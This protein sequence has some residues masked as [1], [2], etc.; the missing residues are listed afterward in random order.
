MPV[1]VGSNFYNG[2][3]DA[4]RR[5]Q[6]AVDAVVALSGVAPVNLQWRDEVVERREMETLAVLEHDSRSVL[7]LSTR[8]KPI[9]PEIFDALAAAAASRSCRYFAFYNADI[10]VTQA[11]VDAIAGLGKQSY[12]VS[13]MDVDAGTGRELGLMLNGLDLFAF[14]VAWWRA[15]RHRFRAYILGEWFYDPV[16]AS[17]MLRYGDGLVLNRG[18]EIRHDA[19]EHRP[20]SGPAADY[21]GY[22]AALDSPYFSMWVAY[23]AQLDA[24]RGRG[25]SEAEELALQREVFSRPARI[26][27]AAYHAARCAKAFVGYRVKRGAASTAAR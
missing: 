17:L 13:R 11:A 25:A 24:L 21:N 26:G 14:D 9:M 18:G 6:A 3:A 22:L 10:V 12:A 27:A 1:L 19:H 2:D 20:P 16:F 15:E 4:M 7:A 23:R 5:Q 8:R